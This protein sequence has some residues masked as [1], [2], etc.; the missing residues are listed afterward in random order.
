MHTKGLD[1]DR[2]I[3]MAGTAVGKVIPEMER[4]VHWQDSLHEKY[5]P[6]ADFKALVYDMMTGGVFSP[7]QLGNYLAAL[8]EEKALRRGHALDGAT[9]LYSVHGAA[10][11]LMRG[12]NLLRVADAT[13]NLNSIADGYLMRMAA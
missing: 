5:V 1:S 2:L 7:G 3:N 9:S 6:N 8:N 12:W 10:T 4:L 13:R 11:R